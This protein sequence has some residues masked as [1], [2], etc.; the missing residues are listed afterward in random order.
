MRIIDLFVLIV[1]L[2]LSTNVL[3]SQSNPQK[4]RYNTLNGTYWESNRPGNGIK[5]STSQ[6]RAI[7]YLDSVKII[8]ENYF[9]NPESIV[10]IDVRNESPN[11]VYLTMPEGTRFVNLH[12]YIGG[13]NALQ[14]EKNMVYFIND[15]PIDNPREFF[16]QEDQIKEVE[17]DLKATIEGTEIDVKVIRV[18]THSSKSF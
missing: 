12:K 18:I 16:I 15:R 7:F 10:S 8:R 11:K 6:N 17:T 4:G 2:L 14:S 3:F 13:L 1:V 5:L 9:I